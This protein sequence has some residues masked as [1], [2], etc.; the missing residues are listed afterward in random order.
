[1]NFQAQGE[2]AVASTIWY[3][4]RDGVS[5]PRPH[6]L[7]WLDNHDAGLAPM[8]AWANSEWPVVVRRDGSRPGLIAIGVRGPHRYQRHASY[9]SPLRVRR[10]LA[11]EALANA[12]VWERDDAALTQTARI[13]LRE[14]APLLD[15]T[16]W[17]WGVTGGAGF[18]LACGAA[19]LS[20]SSDLDLLLRVPK[21]TAREYFVMLTEAFAAAP[22]RIDVQIDTGRGGFALTEWMRGDGEVLLKTDHGPH[23]VR[24]PW[25][26]HL[27][28]R[29]PSP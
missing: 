1:M 18:A 7:L 15:A 6:D 27:G 9:A 24:D 10:R 3:E 19:V 29:Y 4:D 22:I 20:S 21:A 17:Y 5:S 2:T 16:S 26:E 23:L 14:L 28:D 12:R 25:A 13:A 11:P 8:P